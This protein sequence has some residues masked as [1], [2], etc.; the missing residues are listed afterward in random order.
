MTHKR[1]ILTVLILSAGC[2]TTATSRS[3]AP[4]PSDARL[5]VTEVAAAQP[6]AVA[7][8]PTGQVIVADDAQPKARLQLR[9]ELYQAGTSERALGQASLRA[10]CDD[11]GYPLVGNV[12]T[13]GMR[14]DV[15]AYCSDVRL[16][17]AKSDT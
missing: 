10:L 5:P 14:Y 9:S 16:Q 4:A 2:G 12:A 1:K 11:H 7:A 8:P 17:L 15:S 6:V 13:K 3:V